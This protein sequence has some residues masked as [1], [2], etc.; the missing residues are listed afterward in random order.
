MPFPTDYSAVRKNSTE[1]C[2]H[3]ETE[4]YV[5]QSMPDVSP[6]KWHLAHT[7]WFFEHFILEPCL[8]SYTPFNPDHHYLF[9][10]YYNTVGRQYPRAARGLLS[11]PTMAEVAEYRQFVDDQM[12]LL[13]EEDLHDF[14][15]SQPMIGMKAWNKPKWKDKRKTWRLLTWVRLMLAAIATANAS[16]D[17]PT[18][19]ASISIRFMSCD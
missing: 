14:P 17:S 19:I 2:R 9:N 4:D 10:S 16:I 18:A 15:A 13:L 5:V 12:L 11:R 1:L 8:E 3:L 6:T 7:T